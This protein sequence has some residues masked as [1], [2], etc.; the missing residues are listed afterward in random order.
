MKRPFSLRSDTIELDSIPWRQCLCISRRI[1]F[2]G[3]GNRRSVNIQLEG[4][5][6]VGKRSLIPFHQSWFLAVMKVY[7]KNLALEFEEI[8]EGTESFGQLSHASG[9][10]CRMSEAFLRFQ[11]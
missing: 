1:V 6:G 11:I 2:F 10:H 4:V 5:R 7:C 3:R 9:S 8:L